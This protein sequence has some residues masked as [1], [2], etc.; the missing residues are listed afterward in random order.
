[1]LASATPLARAPHP[2]PA[3]R[4]A[5]H[6]FDLRHRVSRD[7]TAECASLFRPT[8]PWYSISK[9]SVPLRLNILMPAG[10]QSQDVR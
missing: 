6:R 5:F 2:S 4:P 9:R 3:P 7:H 10:R 1:M 8:I